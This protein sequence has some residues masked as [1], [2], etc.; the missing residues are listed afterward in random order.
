MPGETE[1]GLRTGTEGGGGR[2]SH[3]L[4]RGVWCRPAG[5][6]CGGSSLP[7]PHP[8]PAHPRETAQAPHGLARCLLTP[9]PLPTCRPGAP[10]P[11]PRRACLSR[12]V[13][14]A[15]S[16]L[17]LKLLGRLAAA[18]LAS[19]LRRA[20]PVRVRVRVPCFP[21]RSAPLCT[22]GP[23]L[24]TEGPRCLSWPL[25]HMKAG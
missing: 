9:P 18:F 4:W 13:C 15:G 17:C 10:P 5:H 16:R 23:C 7:S 14:A 19:A 2:G 20:A 22:P 6:G 25:R 1:G 8:A 3:V 24:T 11:C 12:P 21:I